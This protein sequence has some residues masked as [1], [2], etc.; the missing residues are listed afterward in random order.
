MFTTEHN[1]N[2]NNYRLKKSIQLF[3]PCLKIKYL[4]HARV[5]MLQ[6]SHRFLSSHVWPHVHCA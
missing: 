2:I 5:Q 6:A 3:M 1:Y 4:I